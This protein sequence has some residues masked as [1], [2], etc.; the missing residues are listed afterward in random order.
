MTHFFQY[1]WAWIVDWFRDR[2]ADLR[3]RNTGG[4]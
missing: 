3:K 4:R 1:V 2:L